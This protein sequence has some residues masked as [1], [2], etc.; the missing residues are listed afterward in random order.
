MGRTELLLLCGLALWGKLGT[1]LSSSSPVRS[2]KASELRG[3]REGV[4]TVGTPWEG[5]EADLG[6]RLVSLGVWE[7]LAKD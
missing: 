3:T 5:P 4:G 7:A 2:L 6:G 1:Q